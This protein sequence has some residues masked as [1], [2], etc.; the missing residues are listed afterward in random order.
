MADSSPPSL[1]FDL[2][3][4][5]VAHLNSQL[6]GLADEEAEIQVVGVGGQA[7][8]CSGITQALKIVLTGSAGP[9]FGMLNAGADLDLSGD[10]G[11]CCGHSMN[12]GAI[13]VRGHAD[14][15]SGH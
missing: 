6:R 10:A 15:R 13:L 11:L 4:V 3:T 9:Y 2:R 1:S 5:A 12:A 14:I 8:V 7:V